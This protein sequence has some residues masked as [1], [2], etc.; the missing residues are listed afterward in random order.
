MNF[1]TTKMFY[2]LVSAKYIGVIP[3]L[4]AKNA[5]SEIKILALI[6]GIYLIVS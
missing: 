4:I 1:P 2:G 6:I 5:D 3:I